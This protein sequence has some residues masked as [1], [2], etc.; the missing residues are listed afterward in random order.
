MFITATGVVRTFISAVGVGSLC[1]GGAGATPPHCLLFSA[2][3]EFLEHVYRL[4]TKPTKY[5]LTAF[6][7][8]L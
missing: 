6:F 7:T 5:D 3:F 4:S 2:C 8:G 1:E